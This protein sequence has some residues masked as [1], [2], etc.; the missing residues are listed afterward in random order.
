MKTWMI[1]GTSSSVGKS[2]LVA[3]LCRIFTR[4]G[5]KVAP[6]KAQNMSN[7]AAVCPDGAEIGRA[8]AVQAMAAR[9]VPTADLNPVLLKPEA[10]ARAQVVLMG[11]PW[12]TLPA[13]GY[14]QHRAQLWPAITGALDRLRQHYELVI[15]EGA[16]SPVELNLR[17]GDM[18]NMALARH[19]QCPVLLAGDIDRGGVFAQLLGTLWLLEEEE[20]RLVRGLIVNK[21][22][23]DPTLFTDGIRILEERSGLPVLGVIP[24]LQD[25]RLPEEDAVALDAAKRHGVARQDVIDIAVIRLPRISNFDDFD[26]LQGE[27]EVQ[28][29]YVASV[30]ELGRPHAIILPGTKSTAGDLDWLGQQ[31]LA[32]TISQLAKD[33]VA[34]VGICGGYQML[35]TRILDPD[36]VESSARAIAGLG[37]LPVETTFVA[38]KA[39][40]QARARIAASS[41][42]LAEL[43]G[44][45]L[46]GYEIHMGRTP[47]PRPWLEIVERSGQAAR[48]VDGSARGAGR[49]WGCYLH[50]LFANDHFRHAWLRSLGWREAGNATVSLEESFERLADAVENSLDMSTLDA[51]L[52]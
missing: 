37:L 33:G 45:E 18:V 34:I 39:T 47:S 3:A 38:A 50:G 19:A 16:G 49:I 10:D 4:R 29:R 17:A 35:G 43:A 15:I 14:Y 11:R 27:A 26:A 6:F 52:R 1:Q 41:G 42:W 24:Y 46:T 8:Q 30:A 51:I 31:G 21:F 20:R 12:K 28:V 9:M 2:L 25:L 7:N 44:Q 22:R 23:G 32:H 36:R 13:R 48:E 40:H 5:V